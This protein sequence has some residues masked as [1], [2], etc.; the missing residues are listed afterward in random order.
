MFLIK[1][2]LYMTKKVKAKAHENEKSFYG[3]IKNIF[4]N[5]ERAFSCQILSPTLECAFKEFT[6]IID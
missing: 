1:S 3:E 6:M 4:H 5:F 2:I